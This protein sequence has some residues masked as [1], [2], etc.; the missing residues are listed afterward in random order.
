MGSIPGKVSY[1]FKR[2]DFVEKAVATEVVVTPDET[3]KRSVAEELKV[4]DPTP[5]DADKAIANNVVVPEETT[6]EVEVVEG[7]V[8]KTK[9]IKKKAAEE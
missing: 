4:P 1:E 8:V 9:K 5:V 2:K 7:E 3:V 6:E